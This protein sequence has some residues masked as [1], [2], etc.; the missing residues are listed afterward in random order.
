MAQLGVNESAAK[1]KDSL[2]R[3]FAKIFEFEMVAAEPVAMGE[4]A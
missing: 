2:A 3:N 4:T 1:V